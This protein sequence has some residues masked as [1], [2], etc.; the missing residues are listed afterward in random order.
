MVIADDPDT[1]SD[2][3]RPLGLLE[4]SPPE[5]LAAFERLT[6]GDVRLVVIC[7]HRQS[8]PVQ[9]E[10]AIARSMLESRVAVVP[11]PGGPLG[12]HALAQ[13]AE[14][15]LTVVGRPGT[16][17]VELLPQLA[18]EILD[19]GLVQSVTSLDIAGIGLRHHLASYLPGR[20][21]FGIQLTPHPFVAVVG[22]ER[23]RPTAAKAIA[24]PDFGATELQMLIAGPHP[25]PAALE[26]HLA[27]AGP[28]QVVQAELGLARYWHDAQAT[29]LV[30]VPADPI[31]WLVQNAPAQTGS[32][33]G[34]CSEPLAFDA[35][36]C[37]FCGHTT[38]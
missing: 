11:V 17:V 27:V 34:W 8:T 7:G 24:R 22:R 15:S 30:V 12:Q 20:R 4:L 21:L 13:I 18:S 28:V 3:G 1:W 35:T 29:E 5:R 2:D 9:R 37:V 25:V 19:I 23:L 38:R 36:S 33:C 31:E 6:E 16:V 10:A 26:Q 14:Q 32:P